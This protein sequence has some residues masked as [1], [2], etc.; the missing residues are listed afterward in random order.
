MEREKE[1][2]RI[3]HQQGSGVIT[4]TIE[5]AAYRHLVGIKRAFNKAS[6]STV[7]RTMETPVSIAE[8]LAE[9]FFLLANARGTA[10]VYEKLIGRL[11]KFNSERRRKLE[12]LFAEVLGKEV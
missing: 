12:L 10:T 2:V 3:T 7:G 8:R 6:P 4:I 9:D 11:Y 1:P 5:G